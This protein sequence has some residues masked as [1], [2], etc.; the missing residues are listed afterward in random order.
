M[1]RYPP[2]TH[3]IQ[4][5]QKLDKISSGAPDRQQSKLSQK[6]NLTRSRHNQNRQAD[7]TIPRKLHAKKKHILQPWRLLLGKTRRKLIARRTLEKTNN[8][9][10]DM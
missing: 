2:A 6:E 8:A 10:K 3:G 1:T 7:T 5:N 9:R 4:K